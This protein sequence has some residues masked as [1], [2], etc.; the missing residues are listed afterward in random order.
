MDNRKLELA[1]D[2]SNLI[3][4]TENALICDFHHTIW[5]KAFHAKGRETFMRN[6]PQFRERIEAACL[7]YG[8]EAH[9]G[10]H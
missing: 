2:L 10:R 7:K 6:F 1:N 3:I 5:P 4:R 9:K 8:R